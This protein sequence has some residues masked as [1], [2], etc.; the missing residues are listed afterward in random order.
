MFQTGGTMAT[1]DFYEQQ[2]R[3]DGSMCRFASEDRMNF[4][5]KLK[6]KNI[7]NIEM[8]SVVFAG[9]C[10]EA[11]VHFAVICVGLLNR[12]EGD[13]VVLTE[14]DYATFTKNLFQLVGNFIKS[15]LT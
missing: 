5:Q 10:R 1:D 11:N 7:M 6:S 9:M 14:E 8:E 2:G 12:L 13:Q 15:K 4:L 3:M